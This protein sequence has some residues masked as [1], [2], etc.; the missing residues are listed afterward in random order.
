MA[1]IVWFVMSVANDLA[2]RSGLSY[3]WHQWL[4]AGWPYLL[5]PR[6]RTMAIGAAATVVFALVFALLVRATVRSVAGSGGR[7]A[8]FLAV[9]GAAMLAA[10]PGRLV[11]LGFALGTGA[12]GGGTADMFIGQL[13]AVTMSSLWLGAVIGF[14]AALGALFAYGTGGAAT[15]SADPAAGPGTSSLP[16]EYGYSSGPGA[17]GPSTM[18]HRRD[19]PSAIRDY[20]RPEL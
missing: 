18:G 9:W 10:V 3:A 12:W 2:L 4:P 19:Q 6:S 5:E 16:G 17:T 13:G 7:M 8:L 14:F 20:R 15:A 11:H 1:L